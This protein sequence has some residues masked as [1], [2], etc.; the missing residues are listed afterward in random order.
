MKKDNAKSLNK[1]LLTAIKVFNDTS[2][3]AS[4][5][6]YDIDGVTVSFNDHDFENF[7]YDFLEELQE[8]V[9]STKDIDMVHDY[10]VVGM[11]DIINWDGFTTDQYKVI[12]TAGNQVSYLI[13]LKRNI[14]KYVSN[15]LDLS[16]RDNYGE[17]SEELIEF[18]ERTIAGINPVHDPGFLKRHPLVQPVKGSDD[19]SI[20]LNRF[21]LA[22]LKL[23]CE[24]LPDNLSKIKFMEDQLY[25]YRQMEIE[26]KK[27]L[28]LKEILYNS[29]N[30]EK[31]CVLEIERLQ[32]KLELEKKY[33]I[34]PAAQI[35]P[36]LETGL[37]W[38]GSDAEL[39]ELVAA[40][41]RAE[42]L[43]SWKGEITTYEEILRVF[44]KLLNY[45]LK[46]PRTIH[47]STLKMDKSLTPFL[48]SLKIAFEAYSLEGD[49]DK[50]KLN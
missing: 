3:Q 33:P 44:E 31:L 9:I 32:K 24:K 5:A 13:N 29:N 1:F 26:S 36:T 2:M 6:T 35:T 14:E 49:E 37:V 41:Y 28:S 27:D 15:V 18:Y 16:K 42:V 22:H 7:Y 34:Q 46:G 21:D 43:K 10:I 30:F 8:M 4:L 47:A 19:R 50:S 12:F 11:H 20:Q 38:K 45:Q 25:D 23:E 48:D 17:I 39:L 40:L